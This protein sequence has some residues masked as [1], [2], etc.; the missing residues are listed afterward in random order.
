MQKYA[1]LLIAGFALSFLFSCQSEPSKLMP[2]LAT[3]DS[4]AIMYYDQPNNP[5][6]FKYTKIFD[7]KQIEALAH[8][9]NGSVIE[10]RDE[11]PTDG[12]IYLYHP[13]GV[14]DVLYF[15]RAE[16]CNTFSFIV[17]GEKYFASMSDESR[18]MIDSLQKNAV[19]P[20]AT[21]QQQ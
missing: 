8:D 4:A 14:V 10:A 21:D 9:A 19:E 15:S 13:K 2:G 12:K 18:A 1:L 7:R 17:T 3:A 6:F 16:T 5:R 11:C 20:V